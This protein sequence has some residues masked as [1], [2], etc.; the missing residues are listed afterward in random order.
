MLEGFFDQV[1]KRG[2]EFAYTPTRREIA[3]NLESIK[4]TLILTT[5]ASPTFFLRLFCG[6]AIQRV[7]IGG[8]LKQLGIKHVKWH[9]PGGITSSTSDQRA[10]HL[11]KIEGW[12]KL[13]R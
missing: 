1:I 4:S 11:S 2:A 3:G 6:D 5:S 8:T 12:V 7:I 10:S 9:N 13:M